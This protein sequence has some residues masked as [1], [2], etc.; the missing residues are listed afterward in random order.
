MN[1]LK[2]VALKY[3]NLEKDYGEDSKLY[4]YNCAEVL[5]NSANDYYNLGANA[6]VLKAI[7]PFGG[8]MYA[9]KSCGALTGGLAALGL[10]FGEE[11]PTNNEKL[12][13]IAN[14]WVLSFE[15]KF[16]HTD[17]KELKK[18][19]QDPESGCKLLMLEAADLLES[20]I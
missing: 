13:E 3:I 8:G 15:K 12:K 20:L 18:E 5:L 6:K 14:Q 10:M 11:K 17:C 16:G 2:D 19:Y 4:H 7:I 9:E 1:R